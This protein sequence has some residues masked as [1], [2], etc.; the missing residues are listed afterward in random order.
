MSRLSRAE[1]AAEKLEALTLA[2][3][4]I[5][6][7]CE[8]DEMFIT[9]RQDL[10]PADT[11]RMR[12]VCHRC[13]LFDLCADYARAAKPGAGFWAG[14]QR[15]S[16]TDRAVIATFEKEVTPVDE[17]ADLIEQEVPC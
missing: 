2:G 1:A 4:D 14:L 6:P 17:N 8:G 5:P 15:E 12:L 3:V 13:P 11:Q 7:A 10:V 9:D 16:R